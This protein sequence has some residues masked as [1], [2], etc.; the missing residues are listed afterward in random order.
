MKGTDKSQ[1]EWLVGSEPTAC[2]SDWELDK[3]LLIW[4]SCLS[5]FCSQ[6]GKCVCSHGGPQFNLPTWG[7]HFRGW[8][9]PSH[10]PDFNNWVC[11]R[12]GCLC[13]TLPLEQQVWLPWSHL[14]VN[15]LSQLKPPLALIPPICEQFSFCLLPLALWPQYGMKVQFTFSFCKHIWLLNSMPHYLF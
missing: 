6:R 12:A 14:S 5:S 1:L 8:Q 3:L 4:S 7:V 9:P 11:G 15:I 13:A 10:R 2:S